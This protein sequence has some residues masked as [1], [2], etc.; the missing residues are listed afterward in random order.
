MSA[1]SNHDPYL[2]HDLLCFI[3]HVVFYLIT[4]GCLV[5]GVTGETMLIDGWFYFI[6]ASIW[7]SLSLLNLGIFRKAWRRFNFLVLVAGNSFILPLA[8]YATTASFQIAIGVTAF[9]LL[10]IIA[11]TSNDLS[12]TAFF[13][14][15]IFSIT[16]HKLKTINNLALSTTDYIILSLAFSG[17]VGLGLVWRFFLT[18][19]YALIKGLPMPEHV[20]ENLYLNLLN[21]NKLL[22]HAIA[23]HILRISAVTG[24]QPI[25]VMPQEGE[26][27]QSDEQ[28]PEPS[29][30]AETEN[31]TEDVE[32]ANQP[33]PNSGEAA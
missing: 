17:L 32:A 19:L 14:T 2:Q 15:M 1:K 24:F 33:S 29:S 27:E 25:Q 22:R 31:S 12:V 30:P 18:R 4:T 20:H 21:E 28:S 3:V 8:I 11:F 6:T 23:R 5:Y 26:E 10:S 16:F 7:F 9:Y 13:A